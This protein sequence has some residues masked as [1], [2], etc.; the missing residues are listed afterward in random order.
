[1]VDNK[2]NIILK[3]NILYPVRCEHKPT[4][5]FHVPVWPNTHLQALTVDD[6][7]CT[8]RGNE[9]QKSRRDPRQCHTHFGHPVSI[10]LAVSDG[11]DDLEV[12]FQG[13]D[14]E[15]DFTGCQWI[16]SE[17]QA[18]KEHEN[19][20]S[21]AHV[22]SDITDSLSVLRSSWNLRGSSL[23]FQPSHVLQLDLN[24]KYN[25]IT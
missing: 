25:K 10:V 3:L 22:P 7:R 14:H 5:E 2:Q 4:H 11:M 17:C 24:F 6:S 23:S 20:Y 18:F 21:S 12:A 9:Q 1:M 19:T 15:T 16:G 13:N 8:N